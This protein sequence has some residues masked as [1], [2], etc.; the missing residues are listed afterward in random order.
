VPPDP[1]R[2][3]HQAG[4]RQADAQHPAFG[5]GEKRFMHAG[6]LVHLDVTGS[7]ALGKFA[8]IP[9]FSSASL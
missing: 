4:E 3:Q 2:Q 7:F 6:A 8:L 1:E 5:A 9:F